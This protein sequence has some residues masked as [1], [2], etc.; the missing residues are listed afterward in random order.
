[1]AVGLFGRPVPRGCWAAW[2]DEPQ[3]LS[4]VAATICRVSMAAWKAR[5]GPPKVRRNETFPAKFQHLYTTLTSRFLGWSGA[6]ETWSVVSLPTSSSIFRPSSFV[7]AA[8]LYLL[9]YQYA[10]CGGLS[11]GAFGRVSADVSAHGQ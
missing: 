7:G 11:I 3:A 1:M 10:P 9:L 2:A 6:R 8:H 4:P 5:R